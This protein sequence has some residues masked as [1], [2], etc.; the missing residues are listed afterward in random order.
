MNI[1]PAKKIKLSELKQDLQ[2]VAV[3]Y[4]LFLDKCDL[5]TTVLFG[6]EGHEINAKYININRLE[7]EPEEKNSNE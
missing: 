6:F 5:E 3:K 4:G 1:K 7:V 2:A